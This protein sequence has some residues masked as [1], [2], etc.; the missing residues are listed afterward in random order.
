MLAVAR[1]LIGNP[2]LLLP[3]EPSEGLTPLIARES[4]NQIIKLRD[5]GETILLAEQTSN[6]V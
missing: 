1:T 5:E 4:Q 2:D 6:F 3:D